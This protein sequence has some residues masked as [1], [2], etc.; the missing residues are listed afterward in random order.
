[1]IV[2]HQRDSEVRTLRRSLVLLLVLA[3]SIAVAGATPS[4]AGP[5]APGFKIGAILPTSSKDL[6]FSQS[7]TDAV[8]QV[9]QA[10]GAKLSLT[11]NTFDPTKAKPLF[12]QLVRQKVNLVLAYS[13]SFYELVKE[14]AP[15]NPN[16]VF[17][18]ASDGGKAQKNISIITYSYYELGYS[19]CWLAAKV[20]KKG[21]IGNVG[22]QAV[23]FNTETNAGCRLGAK[24]ANPKVKVLEAYTNDFADQQKGR[25]VA[26]AL[27][28]KGADVIFVSGGVDS[29][30]GAL[31]FCGA[32]NIPCF[33]TTYDNRRVAPKMV[34]SSTYLDWKPFLRRLVGDVAKGRYKTFLYDATL[35]NGGLKATPFTGPAAK[36][37]P[38]G[39][40]SQFAKVLR[41]LRSAKIKFPPS[42]THPGYR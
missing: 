27:I 36:L 28:D 14:L 26:Q 23:P 37:V 1:M 5:R 24:A 12:Q 9:A 31:A 35:G 17:V 7:M 21:V 11:D 33:S 4:A 13:F 18:V 30:L 16:T 10:S 34:V 29:S 39:V 3:A 15:K 25:E 20:S 38:A 32:R 2:G 22:A 6:G 40:R 41:D 19:Q 42:K 8:R